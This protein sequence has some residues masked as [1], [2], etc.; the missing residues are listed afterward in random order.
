MTSNDDE[1]R[2]FNWPF[3]VK[4]R[5]DDER[6]REIEWLKGSRQRMQERIAEYQRMLD[7]IAEKEDDES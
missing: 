7:R 2:K 6:Q 1:P 4:P 3:P 5:T